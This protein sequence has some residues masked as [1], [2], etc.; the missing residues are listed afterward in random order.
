MA[1]DPIE[2]SLSPQLHNAAFARLGLNAR[3]FRLRVPPEELTS[4]L[5][6]ADALGIAGL[7]ITLPHKRALLGV[8]EDVEPLAR[9][10][11]ACNTLTR[12]AQGWR[13]SNTDLPAALATMRRLLNLRHEASLEGCRALILGAGG[14]ARAVAMGLLDAGA[15]VI[16]AARHDGRRRALATD[17]GCTDVSWSQRHGVA[18][19]LLI[20][21]TPVGMAPN[22]DA[23]PF[24]TSNLPASTAV[25]DTIYTPQH[26]ALIR[27][28]TE[29]GCA[30]AGG[31]DMFVAQAALQFASFTSLAAPEATMRQTVLDAL[32]SGGASP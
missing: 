6:V 24:D 5:P 13:A 28:A 29:R 31:V 3:Y 15:K 11:G 7:S 32:S 4:L 26:T 22:V 10:V 17:L 30:V 23:S 2:H 19:D 14:V 21:C 8:L 27:A 9:R 1:G 20:N 16:L 12:G 25:F 18:F